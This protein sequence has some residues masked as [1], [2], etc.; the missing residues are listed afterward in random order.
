MD[1]FPSIHL[2]KAISSKNLSIS[3]KKY[4]IALN[5]RDLR[6]SFSI[7]VSDSNPNLKFG[8]G[9]PNLRFESGRPSFEQEIMNF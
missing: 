1:I 8:F 3:R 6:D 5:F 4:Q 7:L 2:F 9:Y